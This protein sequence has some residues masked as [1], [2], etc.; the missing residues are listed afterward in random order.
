[1]HGEIFGSINEAERDVG[2]SITRRMYF[3]GNLNE[4]L[5]V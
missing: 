3:D 4:R 5:A 1:M 2:V